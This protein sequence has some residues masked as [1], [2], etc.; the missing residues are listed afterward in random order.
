M[1][2][3]YVFEQ[4]LVRPPLG[5]K[6]VATLIVGVIAKMLPTHRALNF[7]FLPSPPNAAQTIN[8]APATNGVNSNRAVSVSRMIRINHLLAI[9]RIANPLGK[10][11]NPPDPGRH[12]VD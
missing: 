7:H 4:R 12:R 11:L 8:K 6:S 10:T 2:L 9:H 1:S 3:I 5:G